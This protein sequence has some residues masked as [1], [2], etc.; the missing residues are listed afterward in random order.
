VI[1]VEALTKRYG[2]TTAVADLS[3]TAGPG[4]ITALLGPNGAGKTTTLRVLLGL[5]RPSSGGA[6]IDGHPYAALARPWEM[7]GAVGELHT[8]HPWRTARVHLRWLARCC[9]L[10]E[11]RVAEVLDRVDLTGAADRRVGS[12]SFGMRQRLSLA[13]ALLGDPAVLVLDEP[14]NG[15]DPQ[16]T[17]WLRRLLRTLADQ[18]RAVLVSSHLLG[19]MAELADDVVIVHRGRLVGQSGLADLL[20]GGRGLEDVFLELTEGAI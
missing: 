11:V 12:Y 3:F 4:R 14:T 8:F 2:R 20:V 5:V 10:A 19:E 9:G 1:T 6:F 18:G 7:V 15:L 13:A 17:R 16:G